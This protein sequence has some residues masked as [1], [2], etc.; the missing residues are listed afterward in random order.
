MVKPGEIYGVRAGRR[1]VVVKAMH[2]HSEFGWHVHVYAGG[3]KWRD[4]QELQRLG[5]V[6]ARVW[7]LLAHAV[8]RGL[9]RKVGDTKLSA[10]EPG[11]PGARVFRGTNRNNPG[12][13][14]AV[15]QRFRTV[16][17]D[18]LD[19]SI[20]RLPEL[21]IVNKQSLRALA[22]GEECE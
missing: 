7:F 10:G 6:V 14:D 1:Y 18:R 13:W 15:D 4:I 11:W 21:N 16:R 19:G 17:K 9:A 8:R 12:D 3:H 5:P 2:E 20:M 22:K